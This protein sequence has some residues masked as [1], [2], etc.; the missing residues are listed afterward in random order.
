MHSRW[1]PLV[2]LAYSRK[3]SSKLVVVVVT[4]GPDGNSCQVYREINERTSSRGSHRKPYPNDEATRALVRRNSPDSL[5]GAYKV[6][7]TGAHGG[8]DQGTFKPNGLIKK[9]SKLG[10]YGRRITHWIRTDYHSYN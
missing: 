8:G 7:L 9:V 6:Q 5:S 4:A 1:A 3:L 10:R 2:A